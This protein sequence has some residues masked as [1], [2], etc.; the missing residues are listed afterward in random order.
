MDFTVLSLVAVP[1]HHLEADIN[2]CKPLVLF[3]WDTGKQPGPIAQTVADPGVGSSF[4]A[5][6]HTFME[7][8]HEIFSTVILFLPLIQEGLV[9]VTSES[10]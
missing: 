4:P 3:L 9:S 8:D 2:P 5:R 6:P 7:I 1:R 10:M